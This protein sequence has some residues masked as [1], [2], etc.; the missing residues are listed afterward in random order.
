MKL[1]HLSDPHIEPEILH[2]IDTQ[3]RFYQALEHI[4]QNHSDADLFV[5]SGDITHFGSNEAYKIF[6]NILNEAKLPK[7]LLTKI[8]IGNHDLRENFK[9]N[10]PYIKTD[11]NGFIQYSETF[12]DKTFIFLDTNQFNT[13]SGYLCKDRQ[14]WLIGELEKK[15][16]NKIYIFMHHNPLSLADDRSDKIGL[17]QKDDFKKILS[18][19]KDIIKH[20]FFGHQHITTSGQYLGITFSSPRSTWSPLVSNFSSKY[21]LG[22]ANT[23]PNYNVILIKDDS[24]IVHTEDFLKTEVNWFEGE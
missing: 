20:I 3:K 24:L 5:I 14:E 12:N 4:R 15:I 16:K 9:N 21:R 8:I 11:K 10:F 23:D 1:I 17:V 18:K 2:N 6:Q 13:D 22:A 7:N 19:Y